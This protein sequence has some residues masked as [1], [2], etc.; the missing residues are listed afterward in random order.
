MNLKLFIITELLNFIFLLLWTEHQFEI[1][2]HFCP[3]VKSLAITCFVA[4]D[5]DNPSHLTV[6]VSELK[7]ITMIMF[8]QRNT[9][10]H[11]HFH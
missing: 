6:T 5:W 9:K 7:L 10:L 8:H 3:E 4:L 2:I 11:Y 1:W